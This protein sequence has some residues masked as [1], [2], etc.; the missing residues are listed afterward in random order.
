MLAG[1]ITILHVLGQ[2]GYFRS[3]STPQQSTIFMMWLPL[4]MVCVF[5][6][7]FFM[8]MPFLSQLHF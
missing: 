3:E 5:F 2:I 1:M 4:P 6:G 7:G 8:M